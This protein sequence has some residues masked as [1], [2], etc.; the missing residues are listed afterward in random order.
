MRTE[1]KRPLSAI[2]VRNETVFAIGAALGFARQPRPSSV[3][4]RTENSYFHQTSWTLAEARLF[5]SILAVS[6]RIRKEVSEKKNPKIGAPRIV[7]NPSK[8]EPAP[9]GQAEPMMLSL[10]ISNQGKGTLDY[11]LVPDC[12]CFIIGRHQQVLAPGE[13]TVVD[14]AINTFEFT[15]KLNKYLFV[16]SN[17]PEAPVRKIM[18]DTVVR[19]AYRFV[20]KEEPVL[21]VEDN[22]AI[23]ETTLV[24]EAATPFNIKKVSIA[25]VSGVVDYKP[26]E[27]ELDWP[28]IGEGKSMRKGYSIKVLV[29]PGIPAGRTPMQ[30][31]VET[32]NPFLKTLV[33]T[34]NVQ[35]G[36]ATV[37]LSIY[38]GQ[39]EK[40]EATAA[41]VLTRPGKPFKVTKV[42][43]D[44]QFVVASF[45]PYRDGSEFR[46]VAKFTGEAPPGRFAGKITV[47]TDDPKQPVIT[48][49]VEGSVR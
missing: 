10:Q 34:V 1:D 18:L 14:I 37:P 27:G 48:I 40:K 33:T 2:D 17:D 36:I 42:V 16:Y 23:F 47:H 46:I 3:M 31:Q 49:P 35:K 22:G 41:V 43:S 32:D 44:T 38:F 7:Y 15:G 12:G 20:G 39:I 5:K 21:Y 45:E 24:V 30:V 6:D 25:G 29:A 13:T 26:W 28:D 9:V 8:F 11:R 4:F 19:P